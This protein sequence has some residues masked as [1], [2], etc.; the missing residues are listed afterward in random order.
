MITPEAF[1]AW[2]REARFL[3]QRTELNRQ[4]RAELVRLRQEKQMEELKAPLAPPVFDVV[5][6]TRPQRRMGMGPM[7]LTSGGIQYQ[8]DIFTKQ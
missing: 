3:A 5:L 6:E 2:Q 7:T 1:E 4:D 8:V